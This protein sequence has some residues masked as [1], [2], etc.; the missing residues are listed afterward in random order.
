M[1]KGTTQWQTDWTQVT[2]VALKWLWSWHGFCWL[3]WLWKIL[4]RYMAM[5]IAEEGMGFIFCWGQ[6]TLDW[7]CVS[8]TAS[9]WSSQLFWRRGFYLNQLPYLLWCYSLLPSDSK[10][11]E[12]SAGALAVG[13]VSG[14]VVWVSCVVFKNQKGSEYGR[15]SLL[16]SCTCLK[17]PL[18][19]IFNDDGISDSLRS[20]PFTKRPSKGVI[21]QRQ[22]LRGCVEVCRIR[23][24][25]VQ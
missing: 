23:G 20:L 6:M 25:A 10:V 3:V 21:C 8:G 9:A 14:P 7:L 19:K 5:H 15:Q 1:Q 12:F 18:T 4:G 16:F 13:H 22:P 2:R 24:W 17:V 11:S